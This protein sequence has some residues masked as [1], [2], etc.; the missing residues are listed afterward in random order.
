M[1]TLSP[2]LTLSFDNGPDPEQTPRVLDILAAR[3]IRAMFFLI[4]EKVATPAGREVARGVIDAGHRVGNHTMTHGTPLGLRPDDEAVAEIARAD[5]ILADFACHP[6]LFRPNGWGA[7]GPHLLSPAAVD[8]LVAQR[9][10]VV[11]WNSVPRDWEEPPSAWMPGALEAV[12]RTDHSLLVLHDVVATTVDRLG[13][14][15]DAVRDRGVEFSDDV[16]TACVPIS[17]GRRRSPLEGLVGHTSPRAGVSR[18][19]ARG[20]TG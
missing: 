3:S 15:L 8:H 17:D 20:A 14:F 16:P 2:R 11:T 4:G 9:H 6:P 18:R 7:L 10:T 5:E 12:E 1:E 13:W 19:R